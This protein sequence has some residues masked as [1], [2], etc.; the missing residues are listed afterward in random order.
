MDFIKGL[1]PEG[2][3]NLNAFIVIVDRVCKLFIWLPCHKEDTAVAT[4][5]LLLNIIIATCGVP[6]IIISDRYPNFTFKFWTNLHNMLGTK[7]A[8]ST[9][10]HPEIDGLAERVI[11]T[12]EDIIRRFCA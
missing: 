4:A 7:H 2:N 9:A 8:F 10:Y 5:L 12:M 1:A 11:P 6:K 3:E